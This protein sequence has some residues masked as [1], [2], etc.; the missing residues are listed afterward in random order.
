MNI[1]KELY[2]KIIGYLQLEDVFR[3]SRVNK[4]LFQITTR[5]RDKW[6]VIIF[7]LM[8]KFKEI[9]DIHFNQTNNSTLNRKVKD[10]IKLFNDE[11]DKYI[12]NSHKINLHMRILLYIWRLYPIPTIGIVKYDDYIKFKSNI[13]PSLYTID[14]V[15]CLKYLQYVNI[16]DFIDIMGK[17]GH[18][19]VHKRDK[20]TNYIF[21]YTSTHEIC[22]DLL[23]LRYDWRTDIRCNDYRNTI[24]CILT[25]DNIRE[26]IKMFDDSFD[27]FMDQTNKFL[28]KVKNADANIK[29]VDDLISSGI[30]IKYEPH[31]QNIDDYHEDELDYSDDDFI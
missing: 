23:K 7:S 31:I 10:D 17:S 28:S 11:I 27:D 24:A 5:T 14:I 9:H 15:P 3:L 13:K 19:L 12:L 29:C 4:N 21:D 6:K 20:C 1:P 22:E 8:S 26:Y 25:E 18:M 16:N 30:L 2:E